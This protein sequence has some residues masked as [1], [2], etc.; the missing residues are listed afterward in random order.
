ML[1]FVGEAVERESG[2]MSRVSM[3]AAALVCSTIATFTSRC[4]VLRT[5]NSCKYDKVAGGAIDHRYHQYDRYYH[6]Y[7]AI[8]L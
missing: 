1:E 6:Y 5:L 3:R 4:K 8:P 2:Q 7:E